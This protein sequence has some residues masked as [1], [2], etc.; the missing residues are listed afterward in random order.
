MSLPEEYIIREM[1]GYL[2]NTDFDKSP[3][4][5][6]WPITVLDAVVDQTNEN[7]TLRSILSDFQ[8][9]GTTAQYRRGDNTWQDLNTAVRSVPLTGLASSTAE[10]TITDNIVQAFGKAMGRI[11]TKVDQAGVRSTPLTGLVQSTGSVVAAD[12]VLAAI[13][14]LANYVTT[15]SVAYPVDG[16]AWMAFVRNLLDFDI[17]TAM[18]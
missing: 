2:D 10:F 1:K 11:N 4:N 5:V 16:G 14:K 18:G 12:T 6:I 9:T 15:N 7:K 17:L 8:T 3:Y 13:G